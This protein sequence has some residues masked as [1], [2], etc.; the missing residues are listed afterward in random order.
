MK[1]FDYKDIGKYDKI[2]YL[3]IDILVI[4]NLNNILD[5]SIN[6]KLYCFNEGKKI[7]DWGHGLK[8]FRKY[9]VEVDYNIEVVS[10]CVLY[11]MNCQRIKQLFTDILKHMNDM[12]PD[13]KQYNLKSTFE[14]DFVIYHTYINKLYDNEL[15]TKY[16][17]NNYNFDK[18][19]DSDVIIAH[20]CIP[21]GNA[22]G[23]YERM[24]SYFDYICQ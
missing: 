18:M 16:I 8:L 12:F 3:D 15:I 7:L 1:P 13:P 4:G 21:C 20:F 6:E 9:K 22:I 23:K 11:F 14:Q 19:Y 17:K 2:L 5:L 24:G 10:T